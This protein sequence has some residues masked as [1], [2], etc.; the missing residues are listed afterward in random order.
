MNSQLTDLFHRLA[1]A[2]DHDLKA[3]FRTFRVATS[4]GRE[5]DEPKKFFD[6]I[7]TSA[8]ASEV[9]LSS[10]MLAFRLLIAETNPEVVSLDEVLDKAT[11]PAK[12][13]VNRSFPKGLKI[14]VNDS[15][16]EMFLDLLLAGIDAWCPPDWPACLNISYD[17]AQ[18]SLVMTASFSQMKLRPTNVDRFF[19]P[20]ALSMA[21]TPHGKMPIS[22]MVDVLS[23]RL[24]G[25]IVAS[26]PDANTACLQ[27]AFPAR[28]EDKI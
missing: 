12:V 2:L 19:T 13:T 23:Y 27:I 1:R 28:I 16:V 6:L 20:M 4:L 9:H 5:S 24:G 11:R 14:A 7:E 21:E 15:H 25:N 22:Y 17:E 18:G 3:P 10:L 26:F 8:L